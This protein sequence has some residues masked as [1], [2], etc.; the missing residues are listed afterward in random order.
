MRDEGT[1]AKRYTSLSLDLECMLEGT[2]SIGDRGSR[3]QVT[4]Q[5]S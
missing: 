2:N 1:E 3:P 4:N 5:Y